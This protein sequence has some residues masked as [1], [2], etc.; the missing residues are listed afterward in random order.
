MVF[1]VNLCSKV[2]ETSICSHALAHDY[3][4]E[5]LYAA[6]A[7]N[8]SMWGYSW[9][10]TLDQ[11]YEILEKQWNGERGCSEMGINAENYKCDQGKL[12][13]HISASTPYCSKCGV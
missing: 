8:C 11:V 3:L 6:S 1:N 7:K 4:M 5:S 2:G 9:D 13:V 10:E 12:F